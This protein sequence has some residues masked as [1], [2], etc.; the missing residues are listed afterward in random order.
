MNDAIELNAR[1]RIRHGALAAL[2]GSL[3]ALAACSG[4]E[5]EATEADGAADTEEPVGANGGRLIVADG[6]QIETLVDESEGSPRFRVWVNREGKPIGV[7]S[8]RGEVRTTRLGGAKQVFSLAP[9]GETLVSEELVPEPHSFDVEV[10]VTIDGRRHAGSYD[11]YETRTTIEPDVAAAAG[12]RT[13]VAGPARIR[14]TL[15]V[16]GAVVADPQ[17]LREV[18][19]RFAGVTREVAVRI[20][21]RV[22][23]GQRLATVESNESLQSYAVTSPIDGQVIDRQVNPGD[24]VGD[25]LLFLVGDLSG[26]WAEFAVFRRDHSR[27]RIG[28]EVTI[29]GEDATR[30]VRGTIAY[31]S[32]VGSSQNQSLTVR[33]PIENTQGYWIPGLFL[34]GEIVTG[35]QEVELAVRNA[36]LQRV[37]DLPAVFEKVGNIYEARLVT[38]GAADQNMTQILDGIAAG[39]V[40]V[41][42]Q[43]YVVKADI[44]KAGAEHSH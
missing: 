28:A 29:Q 27:V 40:Y 31:I 4:G 42:E 44:D 11:S 36:A 1:C 22:R 43:S 26:V 17:R 19:A 34:K 16:Y 18:R 21:D 5:N 12:I 7:E 9:D 13:E 3:I 41:V 33:V 23:R 30:T 32:P 10:A 6:V 20:G 2:L 37:R 39:A 14:Q 38:L 15:P 8:V 25:E 24:A 35:E